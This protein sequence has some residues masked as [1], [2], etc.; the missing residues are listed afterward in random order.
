M[1]LTSYLLAHCRLAPVQSVGWG[2]PD[3][4]GLETVDYFLSGD[5]IER[6]GAEAHY[7]ERLI[8]FNRL[9]C[10]YDRPPVP[11]ETLGRADLNLP[12]DATLY[13]CLQTLFKFHPDFDAVLHAI[14][15]GDPSGLIVMIDDA[16][17]GRA[18]LLRQRWKENFPLLLDRTLFLPSQPTHR[19]LALLDHMDV[20]L[21]PVHFGSGN[22][23]YEAMVFGTPVVTWPGT[24]MRGRVVD[25]CYRQ[26]N[27]GDA[28]P[29]V[30]ELGDYAPT[31]LAFGR[32]PARRRTF[33]D[34]A[35]TAAARALFA[36]MTAV[37]ELEDFF[38]AAIAA[39]RQG[40]KLDAG[41]RPST[42]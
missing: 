38:T 14:V 4:T 41:W 20:L 1:T 18:S 32:D 40:R 29:V 42:G 31:A 3:T 27:M 21:D 7:S 35:R 6:S 30:A 28:A 22:S 16:K 2:H 5:L 39:G 12:G 26:M 11:A 36:D 17:F 25:G 10:F 13:G 23:F 24:F 9:P 19:Y 15:D 37:R 8:R 33:R 34:T